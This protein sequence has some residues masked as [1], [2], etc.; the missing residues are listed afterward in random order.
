[1]NPL[2]VM[3]LL[4]TQREEN[5]TYY[6]IGILTTGRFDA[7][8]KLTGWIDESRVTPTCCLVHR[9]YDAK[10]EGWLALVTKETSDGVISGDGV[11]VLFG[12]MRHTQQVIGGMKLGSM[13]SEGANS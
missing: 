6:Q 1:M 9:I 5:I 13:S 4:R 3:L 10:V 2:A 11:H 7:S 12:R 8:I